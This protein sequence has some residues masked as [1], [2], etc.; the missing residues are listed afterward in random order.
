MVF[1]K[2]LVVEDHKSQSD[3]V[4]EL[5]RGNGWTFNV[6]THLE[7]AL[8]IETGFDLVL[9]DLQL[10]D[11]DYNETI[12]A[13]PK[14]ETSVVVMS[15]IEVSDIARQ[16]CKMGARGMWRKTRDLLEVGGDFVVPPLS[17]LVET[18]EGAAGTDERRRARRKKLQAL[19]T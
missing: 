9:L 8:K 7:E 19:L 4:I 18:I 11:S 5:L 2:I 15:S 12:A 16:A 1:M 3:M 14:F 13:I 17:G 10:V 6:V